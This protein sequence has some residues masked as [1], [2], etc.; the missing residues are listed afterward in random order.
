MYLRNFTISMIYSIHPNG[1]ENNKFLTYSPSKNTISIK[2]V[3][4]V[5]ILKFIKATYSID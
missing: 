1:R 3:E 4:W 2:H 5:I